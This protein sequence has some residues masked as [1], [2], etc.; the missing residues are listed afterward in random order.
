MQRKRKV[1]FSLGVITA[2]ASLGHLK[3]TRRNN[4]WLYSLHNVLINYCRVQRINGKSCMRL[5]A[6]KYI[7]HFTH[8]N[9]TILLLIQKYNKQGMERERGGRR[10]GGRETR[11]IS[12][13]SKGS[14]M[15]RARGCASQRR[16]QQ[17]RRPRVGLLSTTDR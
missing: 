15:L 1:D 11:M 7:P 13:Q 14:L 12:L 2:F 9:V 8:L 3:P 6:K 10:E 5:F 16:R 17:R 4:L